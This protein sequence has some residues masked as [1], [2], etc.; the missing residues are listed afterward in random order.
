MLQ[1]AAHQTADMQVLGLAGH[2]GTHT[3]DT[4]HDHVDAHPGAAGFLQLEDDIAV[5]D[6]VVLED[7]RRRAAHA[8]SCD[9]MIHL[10]Q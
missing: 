10:I 9:H 6:G 8:G 5:A 3:A 7:H 1:I 4:A 2:P